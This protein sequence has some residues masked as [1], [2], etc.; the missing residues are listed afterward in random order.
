MAGCSRSGEMI[1]RCK[2]WETAGLQYL[3]PQVSWSNQLDPMGNFVDV[4]KKWCDELTPCY[5]S[6]IHLEPE[7]KTKNNIKDTSSSYGK[8]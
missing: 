3:E 7:K 5:G 6:K 1:Q 4:K 2:P 8:Y